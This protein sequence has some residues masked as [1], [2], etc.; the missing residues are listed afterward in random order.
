VRCHGTGA[1]LLG[2]LYAASLAGNAFAAPPA[3]TVAQLEPHLNALVGERHPEASPKALAKAAD[4]I[5][6]RLKALGYQIR[7]QPFGEGLNAGVNVIARL[8][9][10]GS[11]R[12]VV[13]V[14]S[15]Y[16]SR[17]GS[18]GADD[19]ASGVA[20]L[21]EVARV[22]AQARPTTAIE[23]VAFSLEE[24][25]FLGSRAYV[26]DLRPRANLIG[27][28]IL[29]S[30]GYTCHEPGCQRVP[31]GMPPAALKALLQASGLTDEPDQLRGNFLAAISDA[32]T[33]G[34]LPVAGAL[35]KE[36]NLPL[37]RLALP[38]RGRSL[39]PAR[40]SDHVPFWDS[41]LP[42]L[43]LT[44][45][46]YLRNPNYHRPTDTLKTLDRPFLARVATLTARLALRLASTGALP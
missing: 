16:D 21:L 37:L 26:D 44:G 39:P 12:N 6:A 3:I 15:H 19:N 23:V 27:A 29:E 41:G 18:P 10:A 38:D 32:P 5:E 35:A 9:P 40:L 13:V 7:R 45:T 43:Q 20:A 30:V 17:E 8:A 1:T 28:L 22:L 46:A 24:Q 34:L 33:T 2:V 14:G 31:P 4:Y 36:I 42:A 25:G 11:G